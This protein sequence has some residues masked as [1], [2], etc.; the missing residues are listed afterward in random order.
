MEA[1]ALHLSLRELPPDF[2]T[3]I[4]R[5]LSAYTLVQREIDGRALTFYRTRGF[6]VVRGGRPA[7]PL[8]PGAVTRL[9]VTSPP[10]SGSSPSTPPSTPSMAIS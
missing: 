3:V 9:A 4:H 1:Q 10:P 8:A 5:Q 2:R 7:L 6:K